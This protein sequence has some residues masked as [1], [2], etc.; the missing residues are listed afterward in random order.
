MNDAVT[1]LHDPLDRIF[2]GCAFSMQEIEVAERELAK[3][4]ATLELAVN[5]L[6]LAFRERNLQTTKLAAENVARDT[7][8]AKR[9][10]GQIEQLAESLAQTFQI[11]IN[12]RGSS[13]E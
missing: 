7:A 4:R 11:H 3:Q 6:A 2:K 9:T 8:Q 10:I 5:S 12:R 13:H 1:R